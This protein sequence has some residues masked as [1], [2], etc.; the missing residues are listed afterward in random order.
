MIFNQD[1]HGSQDE[2][3]EEVEVDVVPGA[4]ELP[5][6][7]MFKNYQQNK[8]IWNWTKTIFFLILFPL[9][10]KNPKTTEPPDEFSFTGT[11]RG[12]HFL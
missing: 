11:N 12:W 2:G 10:K 1:G 6:T 7:Q 5:V 8:Q 9:K 3:Q 4:V